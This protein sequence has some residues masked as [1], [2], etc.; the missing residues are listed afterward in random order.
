[1][2]NRPGPSVPLGLGGGRVDEGSAGKVEPLPLRWR[3]WRLRIGES[4]HDPIR[5][6]DDAPRGAPATTS[7]DGDRRTVGRIRWL[8]C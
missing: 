4:G 5:A 2:T 1:M 7:A 8:P 3:K 6:C